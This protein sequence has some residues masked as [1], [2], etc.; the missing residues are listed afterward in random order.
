MGTAAK[1]RARQQKAKEAA[2][3]QYIVHVWDFVLPRSFSSTLNRVIKVRSSFGAELAHHNIELDV[4]SDAKHSYFVGILEQVRDLLEPLLSTKAKAPTRSKTPAPTESVEVLANKFVG[5]DVYEPSDEFLNAP[6]IER[7]EFSIDDPFVCEFDP[8]ESL[9]EALVA[10]YSPVGMTKMIRMHDPAVL[11]VVSNTAIEFGK[12]IFIDD[13]TPTFEKHGGL[14]AIAR[15]YLADVVYEN[16][17]F[18]FSFVFD[19]LEKLAQVPRQGKTD[20]HPDGHFGEIDLDTP[21]Q[22]KSTEEKMN[23]DTAIISE[24]WLEALAIAYSLSKYSTTDEFIRGVQ[25][26]RKTKKI[27]ISLVFAAQ[28]TL[29]IN[30]AVGKYAETSIETLLT[31]LRYMSKSIRDHYKFLEGINL[32]EGKTIKFFPGLTVLTE[33]I[34]KSFDWFFPCFWPDIEYL[35][36]IIGEEQW[37][38]GGKPTDRR[39]TISR[40]WL[41]RGVSSS[42]FAKSGALRDKD[43]DSSR[44]SMGVRFIEARVPVHKRLEM[45]YLQNADRMNWNTESIQEILSQVV[46]TDKSEDD[47]NVKRLLV[48]PKVQN[49][50]K[51]MATLKAQA[52]DETIKASTRLSPTRLLAYLNDAMH[53]EIEELAFPYLPMNQYVF[54]L[55]NTIELKVRE[56]TGFP[57]D[58]EPYNIPTWVVEDTICYDRL[59]SL[60]AA[61]AEIDL[62]DQPFHPS[63]ATR[64]LHR[65]TGRDYTVPAGLD[66]LLIEWTKR[67]DRPR[68]DVPLPR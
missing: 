66:E 24:L 1:K 61:S 60:S 58:G 3:R 9:E 18:N 32:M 64:E 62:A 8:S 30:H 22:S 38:A 51:K 44:S 20:I 46:L 16:F 10:Y 35:W 52:K 5:L 25:E 67:T 59:D 29:D 34:Q 4:E 6:N 2:S 33:R 56:V 26:F 50:K 28:I 11:A 40:L 53:L 41:A 65:Q 49:K 42:Q 55:F 54:E 39:H 7:P 15:H 17:T 45:R 37:F 23:H 12:E 27:P 43:V 14:K 36:D 47:G 48:V 68:P 19:V 57:F 63:Q 13:V 21:W 31:R